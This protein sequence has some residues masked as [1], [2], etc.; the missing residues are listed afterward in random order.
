MKRARPLSPHLQIYKPQITSVL[1]ILHRAMGVVLSFGMVGVVLWLFLVSSQETRCMDG[2]DWEVA[3]SCFV[4]FQS[5]FGGVFGTL[6]LMAFSFAFF[7]H[8][9]NGI[10]HLF[11]DV[12]CGY[13]LETAEKTGLLV[14]VASFGL[15]AL[16]WAWVLL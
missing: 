1:S 14:V 3:P 10:R 4:T 11:W 15:T 9:S 2:V 13:K 16:L 8:L 6:I 12:G 7:Y 5:F